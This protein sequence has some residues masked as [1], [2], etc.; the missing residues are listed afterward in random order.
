[1]ITFCV[2]GQ[3]KRAES[4]PSEF[5]Q[6]CTDFAGQPSH[7]LKYHS[8]DISSFTRGGKPD[9]E[10]RTEGTTKPK[11]ETPGQINRFPL[12]GKR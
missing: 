3:K 4:L 10:L 12:P 6:V 7:N 11:V 5:L 2:Q 8:D 9:V 1:V